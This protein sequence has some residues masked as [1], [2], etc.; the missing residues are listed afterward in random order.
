MA[1]AWQC[2]CI[3]EEI[4]DKYIAF[5][6]ED[7]FIFQ[8]VIEFFWIIIPKPNAALPGH[9]PAGSRKPITST[10]KSTRVC[11]FRYLS[12]V[13]AQPRLPDESLN[14][15]SDIQQDMGIPIWLTCLKIQGGRHMRAQLL[16]Q[17]GKECS[18][19][20]RVVCNHN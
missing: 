17:I 20:I 4:I 13:A 11:S 10:P 2:L 16:L 7:G 9:P 18:R 5:N 19:S 14:P 12:L 15:E 3:C 6:V 1:F 8:G